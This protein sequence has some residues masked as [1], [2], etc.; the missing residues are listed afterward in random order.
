[1]LLPLVNIECLQFAICARRGLYPDFIRAAYR[2][3]RVDYAPHPLG[4]IISL[5]HYLSLTLLLHEE[6]VTILLHKGRLYDHIRS[7]RHD[8]AVTILEELAVHPQL[9]EPHP[10]RRLRRD[11]KYIL[12]L[13]LCPGG[14]PIRT[15]D[16]L[17]L[18]HRLWLAE[19]AYT[20]RMLTAHGNKNS[21]NEDRP[22]LRYLD[23]RL[24]QIPI[25]RNEAAI[26]LYPFQLIAITCRSRDLHYVRS[27]R[28][29]SPIRNFF[30]AITKHLQASITPPGIR[31]Q[32][33]FYH[34]LAPNGHYLDCIAKVLWHK[35]LPNHIF[36]LSPRSL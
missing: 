20:Q 4:G 9:G 28:N 3:A 16:Y 17:H 29:L 31:Q 8:V 35:P 11:G 12:P 30:P 2:I 19:N 6:R 14:Q 25:K 10:R 22:L 18:A 27:G 33:R 7:A 24:V 21:L 36:T 13:H 26:H 1:M 5:H 23:L 15:T 34:F 32:T